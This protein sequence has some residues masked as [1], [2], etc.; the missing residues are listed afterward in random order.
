MC[1]YVTKALKIS[2]QVAGV[3]FDSSV[4]G[5]FFGVDVPDDIIG[6]AVDFVAGS[7]GHFREPF[8]LCLVLKGIGREVDA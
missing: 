6:E 1:R 5:L 7:L 3:H 8:G 4:T 2:D